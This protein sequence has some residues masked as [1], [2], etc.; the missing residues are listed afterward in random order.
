M[1][2]C[3]LQVANSWVCLVVLSPAQKSVL[4]SHKRVPPFT[5]RKIP[6]T[7]SVRG[8]VDTTVIE[9]LEGLYQLKNPVTSLGIESVTFRLVV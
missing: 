1:A 6:V 5:S 8:S 2:L 9:E 7:I 3:T 4:V